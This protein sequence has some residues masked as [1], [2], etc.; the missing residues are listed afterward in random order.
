M[1]FRLYAAFNVT[2]N[3]HKVSIY[4]VALKDFKVQKI[5]TSYNDL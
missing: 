2:Q 1:R 4:I 3:E 5:N